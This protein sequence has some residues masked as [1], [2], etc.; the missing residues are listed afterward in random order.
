MCSHRHTPV[1]DPVELASSGGAEREEMARK[2]NGVMWGGWEDLAQEPTALTHM[3][4]GGR[5]TL[6]ELSQQREEPVQG[7]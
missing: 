2:G 5:N 6:E 1:L 7:P 4:A 3:S